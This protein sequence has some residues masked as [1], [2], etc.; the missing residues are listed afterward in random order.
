MLGASESIIRIAG[1]FQLTTA[2]R[3]IHT[4]DS[5]GRLTAIAYASGTSI[6]YTYTDNQVTAIT[7][8]LGRTLSF[9]Y[10]NG[11]LTSLATPAGAIAYSY[12]GNGN[13]TAVTRPDNSNQTYEYATSGD[14]HNLTGIIDAAGI[15]QQTLTY[16]SS[17]R[18]VTS[19]LA[20]NSQSV[21]I[22]YPAL[23]TRTVTDAQNVVSTYELDVQQGVAR[24]KSF[25][26]PSC[27]SC[28]SDTGASYI[29]NS[30]QQVSAITDAKGIITT[31]TYDT[32]G[33]RLTATEASGTALARTTTTTYTANN[34]PAT[35]S[36][37][38][39]NNPGQQMVTTNTYD[40][41]MSG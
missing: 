37:P 14:I 12:D 24:V 6:N 40:A 20:G 2:N 30:R 13:L 29:Y 41:V 10:T 32:K 22:G 39:V 5:Q 9:T 11:K 19:S 38:S 35:V 16:D 25:T 15:R 34:Q 36:V 33:N 8:S 4:Y 21:T 17:D 31:Y 3:D 27:S 7:D 1:G 28:G 18:V 26:G 23:L